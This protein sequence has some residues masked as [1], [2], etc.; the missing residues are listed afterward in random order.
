MNHSPL[1]HLLQSTV[2]RQEP[3]VGPLRA[4]D[5]TPAFES[6]FRQAN[7]TGP[8]ATAPTS[9]SHSTGPRRDPIQTAS[10]PTSE[11]SSSHASTNRQPID[12]APRETAPG[13]SADST[14]NDDSLES[15]LATNFS[16]DRDDSDKDAEVAA[17]LAFT[18]NLES[19]S[20]ESN[21][22]TAVEPVPETIE[23]AIQAVAKVQDA[24]KAVAP[25]SMILP[26]NTAVTLQQQST[27]DEAN[28]EVSTSS[29]SS[30]AAP[31]GS[32]NVSEAIATAE[33]DQASSAVNV[34]AAADGRSVETKQQGRKRDE[35]S[36]TAESSTAPT[37][38]SLPDTIRKASTGVAESAASSPATAVKRVDSS[39]KSDKK[40]SARSD[41][42]AR[43]APST[44]DE[45]PATAPHAT[46]APVS[47]VTPIAA[48]AQSAQLMA[49]SRALATTVDAVKTSVPNEGKPGIL[50][51]LN[52]LE[53]G[54]GPGTRGIH[55][56]GQQEAA[57]QVDPA[58]FISRVSRAIQT[59][60]E[61]GGPLQ[62]RL[63]PPELGSMRIEL[64]LNQGTL[65]ATVETDNLSAKQVLLDNLPALRDR[66]ADQNI[67]VERFDVDVRRDSAGSQQQNHAP[68]DRERSH[69][70]STSA[71]PSALR[72]STPP[73]AEN[74][75]TPLRRTISST[76]INVVA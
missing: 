63:S 48:N 40:S 67:K 25:E 15:E 21:S 12:S 76:S 38:E 57:P 46:D 70:Q 34:A 3:L 41:L 31:S 30:Q 14:S 37:T 65:T 9:N 24:D 52:R 73:T 17:L 13:A 16:E 1:E 5:D 28:F 68:H 19:V 44:P 54:T 53:R 42:Q 55:Q 59:A 18:K 33:S 2:A 69:R 27:V 56:T 75:P 39:D 62:L 32:N 10:R 35:H 45:L 23:V 4:R 61:R 22:E 72:H 36:E 58:R 64:S 60:H 71:Q 6:H 51:S 11:G 43:N 20:A 74:E 66:L 29:K 7:V 50:S 8:L 49:N 26:A 47:P